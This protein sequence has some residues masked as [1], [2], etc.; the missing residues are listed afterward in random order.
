VKSAWLTEYIREYPDGKELDTNL[1]CS[2][3]DADLDLHIK[4]F[5]EF[6]M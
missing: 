2:A 4:K 1:K 5:L 6:F 3:I